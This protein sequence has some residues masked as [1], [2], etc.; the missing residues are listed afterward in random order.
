MNLRFWCF[1]LESTSSKFRKPKMWFMK[2][3][4][5][6]R[7]KSLRI[8]ASLLLSIICWK[9][10]L[11]LESSTKEMSR[12]RKMIPENKSRRSKWFTFHCSKLWK[13]SSSW[14]WV[15]TRL[16]TCGHWSSSWDV[17]SNRAIQRESHK[18]TLTWST[19]AKLSSWFLN[20]PRIHKNWNWS[21]LSW[22]WQQWRNCC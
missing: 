7:L 1:P 12:R 15:K 9:L 14:F 16:S 6:A 3:V 19:T 13:R 5:R 22:P 10:T 8:R 11:R 21:S 18:N 17:S 4:V 20:W 2:K